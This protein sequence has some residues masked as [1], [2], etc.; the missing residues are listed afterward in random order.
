VANGLVRF[1]IFVELTLIPVCLSQKPGV[2]SVLHLMALDGHHRL[3]GVIRREFRVREATVQQPAPSFSILQKRKVGRS[4]KKVFSAL[5]LSENPFPVDSIAKVFEDHGVALHFVRSA[6]E[7][8]QMVRS[9]RFDLVVCDYDTPGASELSC[10]GR[11]TKWR[12]I[13]MVIARGNSIRGLTG[14]KVHFTLN[15]PATTD[16]LTKALKAAYS[17]MSH[18]RFAA[19]RHAVALRPIAGT[20]LYRGSQRAL[21]PAIISDISQTGLCLNAPE[22]LPQ[23]GLISVNF[24]LPETNENV[25]VLGT[26]V[27]SSPTGKTGIKF[28]HISA[29]QQKLLQDRLRARFPWN[30]DLLPPE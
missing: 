13:S 27:W 11:A 9:S 20:L 29:H 3:N 8:E 5:L 25:H 10:L 24:P 6:I 15:K 18:L 2:P 17:T 14:K 16:L 12:G 19:Y 22:P 21:G 30:T 26:V 28:N 23:D 1:P 7:V 4:V